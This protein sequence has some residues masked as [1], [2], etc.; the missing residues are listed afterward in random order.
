[1]HPG[2]N[3]PELLNSLKNYIARVR[4]QRGLRRSGSGLWI[5]ASLANELVGDPSAQTSLQ[6]HLSDT[7]ISLFT[8]NGFPYGDFHAASVKQQVY[9]PDWSQPARYNYTRQLAT[10]LAN[11][12]LTGDHE[13]TISTLPLGYRPDWNADKHRAAMQA[14]C[15]LA[16]ELHRLHKESGQNIWVCLEMEPGC[17]LESTSETIDFFT[18]QLPAAAEETGTRREF[19]DR[20]LGVC[21]DVCHQAVMF[22]DPA[23][24][25]AGLVAAGIEI[26]KI[27]I[28]S[29]LEVAHPHEND[30][31]HL[32]QDFAEPKYLHQVR[33]RDENGCLQGVMDLPDAF[34]VKPLHQQH[35]WRVHFHVPIQTNTL[36]GSTLGTTQGEIRSVLDFLAAHPDLHPHL[37]VET[38]TWQVLPEAL[39]PHNDKQLI[40]GLTAELTW[41]ERE[42]QQRGL[43]NQ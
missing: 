7:G 8:L 21:Y 34:D 38:Y 12:M 28:S 1:V 6:N 22:E 30:T 31:R 14:L 16:G 37:E 27:Q 24:S 5:C 32:L 25:I 43:L 3:L 15:R 23:E 41:L 29:A 42:L 20:H 36:C 9:Q 4:N 26:G 33:C 13:G 10:I 18:R 2:E 19:I 11:C 39:R 40:A 17:V 35:P